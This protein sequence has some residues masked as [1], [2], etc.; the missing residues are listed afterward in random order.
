[1][2]LQERNN[3]Q[4]NSKNK[5]PADNSPD[6]SSDISPKD[7]GFVRKGKVDRKLKTRKKNLA[8]E[9]ED[10]GI[11]VEEKK[12]YGH[13]MGKSTSLFANNPDIP[14]FAHRVIH[15][16]REP[17]FSS[18]KFEDLDI[19][20]YTVSNLKQNL[21][22]EKL[23][24]VQQKSIPVVLSGRDALIRSQT[25]SGKT[26][27]YALPIVEALQR[28]RPKVCRAD[29]IRA[30]V[31]VPT[32][33]LALQSY[34]VFIKLVK[35][36]TWLVPGCFV[37]GEKRKSE[38]ARLRKGINILVGT[39]GRLLDHV[40]KTESFRLDNVEWLVLDE[41]DRLLD[42]GYEQEVA[43]FVSALDNQHNSKQ[44]PSLKDHSEYETDPESDP[45]PLVT[46]SRSRQTLLLSA[47]LTSAVERLAG[48]TLKDP[49]FVDA[50]VDEDYS[51]KKSNTQIPTAEPSLVIPESLSQFYVLTPAKLRLVTLATFIIWKCQMH[52]E[53]SLFTRQL[54]LLKGN[55][56]GVCT[57]GS[58]SHLDKRVCR[59]WSHSY[60]YQYCQ[61]NNT[62]GDTDCVIITDKVVEPGGWRLA[63]KSQTRH[64]IFRPN[65]TPH[66]PIPH[67]K[68]NPLRPTINGPQ[69]QTTHAAHETTLIPRTREIYNDPTRFG[70]RMV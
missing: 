65:F 70:G 20:P 51:E 24:T 25:G 26:L 34:E 37:G 36:F 47:T 46:T 40:Q 66:P 8:N 48:L 63:G 68:N 67:P 3:K 21:G 30:V 2:S 52:D 55:F 62:T 14:M 39:P 41:A 23:T 64:L 44:Q 60:H 11:D 45:K 42:M 59:T 27:A 35:S 10:E 56:L 69:S 15:P 1:M 28:V 5:F 18:D 58:H 54:L 4:K 53:Q 38:K 16:V 29:G 9:E 17:V 6:L 49:V 13:G 61:P 43:S 57:A 22:L 12:T 19:H 50:A 7:D 33:E 32:R 31:V